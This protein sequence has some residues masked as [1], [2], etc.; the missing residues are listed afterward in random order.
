MHLISPFLKTN[1]IW[2]MEWYLQTN[3]TINLSPAERSILAQYRTGTLSLQIEL[4][5]F[6]QT[7]LEERLCKICNNEC[8]EDELHFALFCPMYMTARKECF[9]SV[10]ITFV[11]NYEILKCLMER[12]PRKFAKYL[13][14][15]WK[16]RKTK[17]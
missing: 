8:V 5:R 1:L 10:E 3:I 6:S 11:N 15:I 13:C 4:G 17:L 9:E 2:E 16:I 12:Y 7:K 14:K